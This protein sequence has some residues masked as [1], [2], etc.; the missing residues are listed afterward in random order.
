MDASLWNGVGSDFALACGIQRVINE[1]GFAVRRFSRWN[2]VR[3]G[4]GMLVGAFL[5]FGAVGV[6]A[7]E[8]Q[9]VYIHGTNQNSPTSQDAFNGRVTKLHPYIR[10]ALIKEPLA[11]EHLLEKGTLGISPQTINF[12]WGDKSHLSIAAVKRNIANPLLSRGWLRLGERAREKLAYTLHDAIWVEQQ[13]NKKAIVGEL[14]DAVSHTGHQPIMLMGHSA[15]SL[16]AFDF[17][18]YR[19]P[20]LNIQDFARDLRADPVVMA[21]LQ[22]KGE[23]YT[24]LEALLSSSG[25]RYDAQGKLAPFFS[26]IEPQ[27]PP[28]LLAIY[29]RN[30]MTSLPDYTRQYCLPENKVRGMVTFG[31]PLAL[32]YSLVA[33]PEKDES[34]LVSSMVSYMLSHNMVWLHV[35]HWDDFIALPMPNKARILSVMSTR[36]AKPPVLN[37]GFVENYLYLGG[38]ATFINAHSWYWKKPRNF[39]QTVAK[40]YH[41]GYLD[42]YPR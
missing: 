4:L 16:V 19:L 3:A 30:W 6:Y 42:W 2:Q 10:A 21:Q 41:Q 28:D 18:M 1:R 26:G 35:N 24:C 40:A 7:E 9:F 33:N 11:S 25:I 36:L 39:A 8:L 27:I 22:E 15:G 14:F 31:S 23:Q 13:T 12:F 5:S 34:Y 20:Y 17:L 29:R 38:G 32:F 37:G